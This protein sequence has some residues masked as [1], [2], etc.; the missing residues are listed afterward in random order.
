[1][2]GFDLGIVQKDNNELQLR[3]RIRATEGIHIFTKRPGRHRTRTSRPT[4]RRSP[5]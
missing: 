3:G 1:M 2:A 5:G 4:A